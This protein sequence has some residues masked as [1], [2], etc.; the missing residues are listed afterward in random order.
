MTTGIVVA[1]IVGLVVGIG[2][3]TVAK[4]NEYT[5]DLAA[6][7]QAAIVAPTTAT[8]AADLRVI[9]NGLEKEHVALAS[10]ATKNG[11]D[12]RA[13]FAASA[14]SLDENSVKI[15]QAIGSVYGQ[16]AADKFLEIWRSHITFFVNYTVAAKKGDKAGMD[17]AVS[18]LGGYIDAISDFLSTANSNLPREAVKELITQHV[19]LLKSVVDAH[20]AA[21]Y[22]KAYTQQ[23][24]AYE[25]IGNIADALSGAIVKQMPAKF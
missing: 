15:S 24:A 17:K 9:L 18:D 7:K 1:L 20:G 21:D 16:A 22:T 12:G 8:K 14:A 5:R 2:A 25:Q 19:T 4:S 13:D 10:I 6:A 11:F 3:T 23:N